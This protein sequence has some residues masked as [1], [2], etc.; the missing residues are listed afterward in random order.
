[1]AKL[2][3]GEGT[4]NGITVSMVGATLGTT[5]KDVG[6][7]CT[8]QNINKW[9]KWKP[10]SYNKLSGITQTELRAAHY[11]LL[12]PPVLTGSFYGSK[13]ELV[14]MM[15]PGDAANWRYQPPQG[16][17]ASSYR[18]GDFRNYLHDSIPP[19]YSNYSKTWDNKPK[20]LKWIEQENT[21]KVNI[22]FSGSQEEGATEWNLKMTD[23]NFNVFNNQGDSESL[24]HLS[25]AHLMIAVFEGNID[26]FSTQ[27]TS[28][29]MPLPVSWVVNNDPVTDVDHGLYFNM[30]ATMFKQ[31]GQFNIWT[32]TMTA[33]TLVFCLGVNL[34][35]NGS[36]KLY[37]HRNQYQWTT[38]N[39]V[40]SH[41]MMIPFTRDH[42]PVVWLPEWSPAN[43]KPFKSDME[44]G[45]VWYIKYSTTTG[46]KWYT[47]NTTGT[48]E[49]AIGPEK[50]WNSTGET[51]WLYNGNTNTGT[52]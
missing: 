9:S 42:Y 11:G 32:D 1:M 10:V 21:L 2:P 40:P 37:D 29:N 46:R 44:T 31:N 35:A 39:N 6:R 16:G 45:N 34:T 17:A 24:L 36:I 26:P 8:N 20:T 5:S 18:L 7:L 38:S 48:Y 19:L 22:S 51:I 23:F 3:S 50:Y 41:A 27:Y 52:S 12:F 15:K 13:S 28:S 30:K 33:K 14:K 47:L 49:K 4:N 43:L 25:N